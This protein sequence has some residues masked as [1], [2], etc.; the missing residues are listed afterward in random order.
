VA[1]EALIAGTVAAVPLVVGALLAL[2]ITLS[3]RPLGLLLGFGAGALVYAASFELAGEAI[4]YRTPVALAIAFAVGA[5]TFYAGDRALTA[6]TGRRRPHRGSASPDGEQGPALVLGGLLDGVPEQLAL[7]LGIASGSGV[8]IALVVAIVLSNLPESLGASAELRRA[9][10]PGRTIVLAWSTVAL[11]VIAATVAGALLLDDASDSVRG[12][13]LAFAAGA[14]LVMLV[15]S[16]IP[17]A[18]GKGGPATGLLT[19]LGFAL[20]LALSLLEG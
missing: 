20:A 11:L 5:L 6:W 9:G 7:G 1:S 10:W 13:V 12:S 16:M 8:P 18:R 19:A 2:R 14:V 4:E 17:E 3:D 15:D